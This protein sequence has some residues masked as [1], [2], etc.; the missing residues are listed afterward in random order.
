MWMDS[1]GVRPVVSLKPKIEFEDGGLGTALKPY[2]V[3]Y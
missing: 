1:Y 2:V 3:K